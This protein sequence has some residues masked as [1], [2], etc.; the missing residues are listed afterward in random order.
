MLH[1]AQAVS[2]PPSDRDQAPRDLQVF[3]SS[4]FDAPFSTPGPLISGS[5]TCTVFQDQDCNR[6]WRPVGSYREVDSAPPARGNRSGSFLAV[7]G[8]MTAASRPALPDP[9]PPVVNG[10]FE[11]AKFLHLGRSHSVRTQ[12]MTKSFTGRLRSIGMRVSTF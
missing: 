8:P 10:R 11:T 12:S 2:V 9:K 1:E 4:D 3:R 7:I 5:Q 6:S